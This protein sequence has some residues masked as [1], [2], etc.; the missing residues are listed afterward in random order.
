MKAL[1]ALEMAWNKSD[2]CSHKQTLLEVPGWW[3]KNSFCNGARTAQ[4]VRFCFQ[5]ASGSGTAC[6]EQSDMEKTRFYLWLQH[7]WV[8]LCSI[9]PTFYEPFTV[10]AAQLEKGPLYLGMDNQEK[11]GLS[12]LLLPQLKHGPMLIWHRVSVRT[13]LTVGTVPTKPHHHRQ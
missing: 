1:P 2:F 9:N 7:K 12:L 3:G 8:F 13:D 10:T 6:M 11:A 5:Y 4:L